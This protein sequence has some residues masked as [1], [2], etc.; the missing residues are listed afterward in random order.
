[1]WTE[2]RQVKLKFIRS[3][4]RRS[5]LSVVFGVEEHNR[6]K[7]QELLSSFLSFC[8][9]HHAIILIDDVVDGET[10]LSVKLEISIKGSQQALAQEFSQR[11]E[12]FV[13]LSSWHR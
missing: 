13:N 2:E 4:P 11:S 6:V 7:F 5:D 8:D 3:E 10:S 9:Q 1:M 12:S